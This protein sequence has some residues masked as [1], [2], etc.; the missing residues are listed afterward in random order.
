MGL[1]VVSYET[2]PVYL[3]LIK[4]YNLANVEF[5]LW[6]NVTANVEGHFGISLVDGILPRVNQLYYVQKH[7]R[8]I[9][10]DDFNDGNSS[11]GL[12]PMLKGYTRL[13]DKS[14]RLAIF[15]MIK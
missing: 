8:Y 13:D 15:R 11:V 5:R 3:R 10:I 12:V 7:S 14:T 2:D 1:D 4:R 9:V 6:D